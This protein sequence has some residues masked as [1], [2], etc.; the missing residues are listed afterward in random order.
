MKN[1]RT[2]L[3]SSTKTSVALINISKSLVNQLFMNKNATLELMR[4]LSLHGMSQSYEMIQSLPL[5]KQP[6]AEVLLAQLL[7]AERMY[8]QNRKV[9]NAVRQA[10]FRYQAAIEEI[11]YLPQR[12]LDKTLMLRLADAS[13]ITR[14]ENIIITGATGCGKS[15]LA[16]AL[17]WQACQ[18][19][20]KVAYFSL[21]KL[22]QRLHQAKADGSFMKELAKLEKIQLLIMDDWGIQQLDT[23]A[24]LTLLQI[25]ED[26]HGKYST[27]ITSQLPVAKWHEY[28]NEPTLADAIL[29]R[30]LAHASRVELKGESMRKKISNSSVK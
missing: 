11:Q 6:D 2:L 14:S 5:D 17:G 3:L 28:I 29:D 19:G 13:F 21:P 30:I 22:M 10:Q 20:Y 27:I 8:R 25:I 9:K 26:R 7:E 15:F 16:T 18:M 4:H 1:R 12:N 23:T 24:R